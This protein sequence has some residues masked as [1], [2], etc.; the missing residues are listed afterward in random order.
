MDWEI[1][2]FR[3]HGALIAEAGFPHDY[4]G[5]SNEVLPVYKDGDL[6]ASNDGRHMRQAL[7]TVSSEVAAELGAHVISKNSV[8]YAKIGAALL[9]QLMVGLRQYPAA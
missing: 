2:H 1:R 5:N 6:S 7:H 4:Q 3:N 9:V 8:I